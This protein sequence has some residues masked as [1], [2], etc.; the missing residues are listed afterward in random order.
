VLRPDAGAVARRLVAARAIAL[1]IDAAG[2]DLVHL[3]HEQRQCFQ[4]HPLGGKELAATGMQFVREGRVPFVTRLVCFG[5][6]VFQS[7]K[8]SPVR[9][10]LSMRLN[11]ASTRAERFASPFSCATNLKP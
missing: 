11:G 3:R 2:V 8:S 7:A 1:R 9:K 10:P 6:Q 5:V 4:L